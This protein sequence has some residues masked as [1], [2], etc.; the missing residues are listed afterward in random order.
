ML[1]LVKKAG[2]TSLARASRAFTGFANSNP[3]PQC[4]ASILGQIAP[5]QVTTLANGMRVATEKIPNTDTATVGIWIDAG[6]R[7][8]TA[9]NNGSAHFLE[10][11]AFKGTTTRNSTEL[12]LE[13]ENMGGH[14]NAYTS[15]EQTCYYAKVMEQDTVKAMQILADMIQNSHVNEANI[16]SERSVILREAEEVE[17]IS[18]EVVFDHLHSTAFQQTSLGRTILGSSENIQKLSRDDLTNFIKTHYT[19]QRM[20]IAAAGAVDH[21]ALVAEAEK[22]FSSIPSDGQTV[23]ELIKSDPGHFTGSAVYMRDPDTKSCQWAVAFKGASWTDPDSI[24]LM[25]MQSMI[26]SW[27]AQSLTKHNGSSEL[28]QLCSVNKLADNF[29]AFNTNYHDTG[30]FGVYCETNDTEDIDDLAWAVMKEISTMAYDVEESQL[31]TAKNNLKAQLIYSSEG[32]TGTAEEIG[33]Q[34]LTYGRRVTKEEMF[35]RIDAVD[36]STIKAV[37][38]RFINNQEVSVAAMGDTQ[39]LPDINGFNRATYQLRY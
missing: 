26:G 32:T 22:A 16:E 36:V 20:V 18:Q 37:A 8:E 9:E 23:S 2:A 4:H 14:L 12:E 15:R 1:Q 6:S 10:H 29:M 27:S 30:L 25:V 24:P 3:T 5:T 31:M 35:D 19:G 34:L 11:M 28:S 38:D 17:G 7:Y 33:R 13:I 21:E 39:F